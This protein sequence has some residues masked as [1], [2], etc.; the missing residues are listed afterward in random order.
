VLQHDDDGRMPA[1]AATDERKTEQRGRDEEAHQRTDRSDPELVAG[2]AR[3]GACA[4]HAAQQEQ[5]DA[6]DLDAAPA[7]DHRV[8][9]LVGHERSK[10]EQRPDDAHD[11]VHA[12]GES[13]NLRGEDT[14]REGPEDEKEDDEPGVVDAEAEAGN[15]TE[16]DACHQLTIS[17]RGAAATHRITTSPPPGMKRAAALRRHDAERRSARLAAQA[18]ASVLCSV[19]TSTSC[20]S[21]PSASREAGSRSAAAPARVPMSSSNGPGSAAPSAS[22]VSSSMR[23]S[24][25]RRSWYSITRTS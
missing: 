18:A 4:R 6:L 1:R 24:R 22:G 11:D 25:C 12:L 15:A 8:C 17:P 16:L 20:G 7:R 5:R 19:S 23:R 10:E 2:G 14:C 9:Q 21:E 13:G 3:L